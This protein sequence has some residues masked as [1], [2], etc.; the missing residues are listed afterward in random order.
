MSTVLTGPQVKYRLSNCS[1]LVLRFFFNKFKILI[2][3]STFYRNN[4]LFSSKVIQNLKHGKAHP[5]VNSSEKILL[6]FVFLCLYIRVDV[7]KTTM[8]KCLFLP[9]PPQQSL[10]VHAEYGVMFMMAVG[11][12]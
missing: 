6:M 5:R 9:L 4:S 1:V 12:W 2:Y 10:D 8:I 3:V 7:A 11:W